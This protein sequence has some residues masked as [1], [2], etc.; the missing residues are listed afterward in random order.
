MFEV[1]VL[2]Q[3]L[4]MLVVSDGEGAMLF[5]TDNDA[6]DFVSEIMKNPHHPRFAWVQKVG[7][8]RR[9]SKPY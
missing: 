7:E 8:Q 3:E 1:H 9:C 5:D 6:W 4:V 2:T